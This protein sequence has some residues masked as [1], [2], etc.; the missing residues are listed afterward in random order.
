LGEEGSL[1][2]RTQS[3]CG[4]PRELTLVY[5]TQAFSKSAKD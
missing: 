2:K 4:E 1:P 5:S 3:S